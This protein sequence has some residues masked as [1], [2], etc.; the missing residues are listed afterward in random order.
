MA[1]F[2]HR[3]FQEQGW[4]QQDPKTDTQTP[5]GILLRVQ[6]ENET[7]CIAEPTNLEVDLRKIA[8]HLDVP[9]LFTMASEISNLLM[10]RINK[11]DAEITL[12]PNNITVPIVS[13]LQDMAKDGAGVRRRDYCCF[14]LQEKLVLVWCNSADEALVQGADVE[15]RLMSSVIHT[16]LNPVLVLIVSDLGYPNTRISFDSI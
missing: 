4:L 3:R 16:P 9:V 6:H 5:M 15:S 8:T 11:D 10:T 2:L 7:Q 14:V 13:S 12:S 1:Q